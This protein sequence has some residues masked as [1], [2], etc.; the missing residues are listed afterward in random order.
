M[1]NRIVGQRLSFACSSWQHPE[2]GGRAWSL[3]D[4]PFLIGGECISGA[5][6]ES[7]RGRAIGISNVN[8]IGQLL[9]I[10]ILH[11]ATHALLI[12]ENGFAIRRKIGRIGVV[13]PGKVALFGLVSIPCHDLAAS[14]GA[15]QQHAS[16]TPDV[17]HHQRARYPY[18]QPFF[19]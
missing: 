15:C 12:K 18:Y 3:Y 16:V 10:S 19:P 2:L 5:F 14:A 8:R 9:R 13:K 11:P 17:E 7:D 4:Y 6:A 1:I